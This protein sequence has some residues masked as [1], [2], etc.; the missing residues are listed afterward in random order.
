MRTPH[1]RLTLS[2]LKQKRLE[3]RLRKAEEYQRLID[4][5]GWTRAGLARHLGVSRAWVT[6]VLIESG[7]S[8]ASITSSD[9]SS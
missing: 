5:N 9:L 2:E 6:I 8:P 7:M 3:A 1:H 4:E